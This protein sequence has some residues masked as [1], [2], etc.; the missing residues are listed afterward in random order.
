MI[1][2]FLAVAAFALLP[3]PASQGEPA[4]V[5]G[6]ASVV[7]GDT[8]DLGAIRIRL[9]GI[10]APEAGQSC[11]R[12]SGRSWQCGTAATNRLAELAEGESVECLALDRD[13]YGRVIG[14]CWHGEINLNA[15]LVEE[16]LAWAFI[17]FSDDYAGIEAEARAARRG[18]WDGESETPWDYRANR[19]ERA[20]AASPRHGCPIKGNIN[21]QGEKI[22]HTPWSPWYERTII[23]EEAG[24][25][26]F[27]DEAEAVAAGW[28]PARSR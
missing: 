21:R 19:W 15:T 20:A 5:V 17:R 1:R 28:R 22:Y 3:V 7:D 12:A 27:C 23:D 6:I 8:L 14:E 25:R 18:I 4:R 2:Q 24:E 13:A 16:G 26:W 9:H 11:R 10:D